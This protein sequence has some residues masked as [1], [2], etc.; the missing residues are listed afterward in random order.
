M[1]RLFVSDKIN[2]MML[3]KCDLCR[4]NIKG[5]PIMAGQGYSDRVDLCEPCGSPVLD[6]LKKH[7]LIEQDRQ[8][9]ISKK[10]R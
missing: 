7:K 6:F 4:K 3:T 9:R 8:L 5:E 10:G 1:T 2:S